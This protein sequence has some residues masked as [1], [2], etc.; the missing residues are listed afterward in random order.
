[1]SFS[2][3]EDEEASEKSKVRSNPSTGAS[4]RRAKE[5]SLDLQRWHSFKDELVK[6]GKDHSF[7]AQANKQ[8]TESEQKHLSLILQDKSNSELKTSVASTYEH[9]LDH[10]RKNYGDL[11]RLGTAEDG[12]SVLPKPKATHKEPNILLNSTI[13]SNCFDNRSFHAPIHELSNEAEFI[14]EGD[15]APSSSEDASFFKDGPKEG[16]SKI[17]NPLEQG[18][19]SFDNNRNMLSGL[20]EED[21]AEDPVPLPRV[22]ESFDTMD[23]LERLDLKYFY[24]RDLSK[25]LDRP[26]VLAFDEGEEHIR[27]N[28]LHLS[29][30][31]DHKFSDEYILTSRGVVNSR[32]NTKPRSLVIGR[33]SSIDDDVRP[34]DIIL[35][36]ADKSISRVHCCIYFKNAFSKQS[37]PMSFVTLLSG[38]LPRVAGA[39]CSVKRLTRDL[40][41]RVFAYLKPKSQLLAFDLG[42]TTGTFKRVLF[43]Q[44]QR[45]KKGDVYMIGNSFQLNAN[46]ACG[47]WSRGAS[48]KNLCQFLAE[49][50]EERIHIRGLTPEQMRLVDHFREKRKSVISEILR[51]GDGDSFLEGRDP[52]V[53]PSFPMLILEVQNPSSKTKPLQ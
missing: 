52:D 9:Y 50:P 44:A 14:E 37:L 5:N 45:V 3:L 43:G 25:S 47:T 30:L 42:S 7:S 6:E 49:E 18:S 8:S 27:M 33:M 2:Q 38:R 13:L 26:A 39:N 48:L 4:K 34:N 10:F 21:E 11:L 23:R 1:M 32:K 53:D 24:E 46:Y 51:E 29:P 36:F 20:L 15:S 12:G 41:A 40:L 31:G 28:V 19:F 22:S 17:E 35:P 16:L